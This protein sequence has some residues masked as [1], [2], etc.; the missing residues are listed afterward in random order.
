MSEKKEIVYDALII[1]AGIAGLTTALHLQNEGLNVK[2]LEALPQV[3]GKLKTDNYH[4]FLLDHGFQVLF[5]AYPKVNQLLDIELLNL[6]TFNP[7]AKIYFN[8]KKYTIADIFR[9]PFAAFSTLNAPFVHYYDT[10]KIAIL[11]R[12]L[13]KMSVEQIWQQPE[14]SVLEF[15]KHEWNFSNNF[16][17]AFF[18]PFLGSIF[19][20]SNLENASSR[21]FLF[22]FKML[23]EGLAAVP[24]Q[25]IQ[26]IAKQLAKRLLPNTIL[27]N[28]KVTNISPKNIVQTA[29]NH[30]FKANAIIIATPPN[31]AY[32]LTQIETTNIPLNNTTTLYFAVDKPPMR[33]KLILLNA[34]KNM[35]VS[36]IAVMSVVNPDIAPPG[37]HLIAVNILKNVQH[38]TEQALIAN[39]KTELS[40]IFN[41]EPNHWQH[42]KTY[43]LPTATPQL[44]HI[45]PPKYENIKPYTLPNGSK[46]FLCGDYLFNASIDGAMQHAEQVAQA[47]SWHL[48]I[49]NTPYKKRNEM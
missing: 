11:K 4:S 7:G 6:Q 12:K 44:R 31:I 36:S 28:A 20:N 3:G 18:E 37:K 33:Q 46:V 5:T 19:L 2:I 25:G 38:L 34:H 32:Q 13:L 35:L 21:M 9:N 45:T 15:L 29:D 16:I 43:Y 22:V 40:Q 47:V 26:A 39:I 48:A 23:N 49:H 42:L 30:Q 10:L 14:T 41:H 24:A 1:G 17:Q 8:H 27:I